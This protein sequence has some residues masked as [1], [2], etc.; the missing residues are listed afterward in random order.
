MKLTVLVD[1]N[2]YIDRYFI[3]EPGVSYFIEDEGTQILFDVG[4]SNAFM[5]NAQKMNVNMKNMD[6]V[7][8]SHGHIDHTGGFF[9]LINFY[10]E[11]IMENISYKK[12]TL[13]AHPFTFL[14]K[15]FDDEEIG[16]MLPEK[17]LSRYFHMQLSKEPIWLTKNLVFLGEIERKNDFENKEPIGKIAIDE[18]MV[19]DYVLD[20]SALVYQS[21]EGLVIITGC[22][23]AG[24]CNIIE[25]A[26]KVCNDERIVDVIGGFHLLDASKKQL[27]GTVNYMKRINAKKVHACHCTDLNAKIALAKETNIKEVGV[28]LTL[29]Y[30]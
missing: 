2:T 24:I 14:T 12:P 10:N 28:G 26:K 27:E 22:S 19:D 8:I 25:Y 29:E 9:H 20:D 17:N 3:G 23:H 15:T 1:N 16:S 30:K 5:K 21:K 4:Y 13:V 7:V 11:A 6:F 18:K